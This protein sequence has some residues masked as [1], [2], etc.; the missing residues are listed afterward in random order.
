MGDVLIFAGDMSGRG[1]IK[2]IK[3]FNDWIGQ[4]AHP[5]KIVVAGNHDK[6]LDG[7]LSS[8]SRSALSS[9][10][11]LQDTYVEIDGKIFYGSPWQPEFM[12]WGFNLKRGRQLERKWSFIHS[13][14][15]VLITHCPPYNTMD[16]VDNVYSREN[17]EHVGCM[18]LATRINQLKKLKVH[19]FGHIHCGYGEEDKG[20]VH[21]VNA[22]VCNEDYEPI[23]PP[24][25]I[26]I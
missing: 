16:L 25:V 14:T 8:L 19:V 20:G 6:T 17:G 1:S 22:S 7:P 21:Y 15:E 23:N 2:S 5:H 26:D 24:I 11:Y 12:S 10:T 3:R 4:F 13:D 9:C 18:D